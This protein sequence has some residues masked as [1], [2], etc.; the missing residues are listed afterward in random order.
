MNLKIEECTENIKLGECRG[1]LK[2]NDNVKW[3]NKEMNENE[4]CNIDSTIM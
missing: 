1:V 3:Q 4:L 2:I